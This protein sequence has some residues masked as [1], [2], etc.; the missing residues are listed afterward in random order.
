M[1]IT[2]KITMAMTVWTALCIIMVPYTNLELLGILLLI[3]VLITRELSSGYT[4]LVTGNR[5]DAFIYSGIIFFIAVVSRR[6]L[7]ILGII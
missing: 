6:I 3:G 2:N 4:K 5:I 1:N 7:S